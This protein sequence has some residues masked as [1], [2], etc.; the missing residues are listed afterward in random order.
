MDLVVN[1]TSDEHPW[2]VES[3]SGPD[4]PK[5]DWY[6][7]RPPRPG[8]RAGAARRRADQLGGSSSPAR[9]GSCHEDS[10]EYYLHLFSRKQPDLN[11]ENPQVRQAIYEMMR[12]WLD[13]G[14]DGFRMDVIN[15][16]SKDPALPDGESGRTAGWPTVSRTTTAA[17]GCTS[18]CRRCIERC[19]P[20]RDE[21]VLTVGEM[22]GVDVDNALLGDRPGAPRAR[23]GV[24]VRAR[25]PRPRRCREVAARP[26]EVAGSLSTF[27]RW[28]TRAWPA[29]AGT[30]CT[31]TTMTS[32]G[33]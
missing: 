33:S 16:I 29:A 32:P 24:P 11:W 22:P 25:R 12:W 20:S 1:H 10:E 9:P 13:R 31:G 8:Q 15:L 14:V 17:P 2:F 26:L 7:W 23:H 27:E 18:S 5:R 30:A 3:A 6:W 28:Q 4:N 21:H 19:S